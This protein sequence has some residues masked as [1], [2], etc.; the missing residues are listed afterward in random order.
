M[1]FELVQ[2][3]SDGVFGIFNHF[4]IP[5]NLIEMK[6][7]FIRVREGSKN[8]TVRTVR[9][10]ISCYQLWSESQVNIKAIIDK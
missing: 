8:L 3:D 2:V 1:E 5:S 4:F 7:D 9:N 10:H 6:E